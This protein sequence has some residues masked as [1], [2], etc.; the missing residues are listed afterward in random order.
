MNAKLPYNLKSRGIKVYIYKITNRINNKIY[1]GQ[2]TRDIKTR[3]IAHKNSPNFKHTRQFPLARAIKKYGWDNFTKEVID[4]ATSLEELN[5][6]ELFYINYFNSLVEGGWGY[7]LKGGGD[8]IG[9]HAEQTKEKIGKAQKGPLNHA[10]GKTGELSPSSKPLICTTTN[11]RYSSATEAASI[12]NL[13]PSHICAVCRGKRGSTGGLVFR[14]IDSEGNIIEP[15]TKSEVKN[16]KVINLDTGVVYSSLKEAELAVSR[17]G[18]YNG[19]LCRCMK[20]KKECRYNGFNFKI[21][22]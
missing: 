20:N 9:S 2:T 15:Q 18:R 19:N 4:T 16:R 11:Q 3:Y 17:N 6:K 7:N 5:Q 1:I 10:F 8:S 13:N 21:I 14:W 22:E 12:L